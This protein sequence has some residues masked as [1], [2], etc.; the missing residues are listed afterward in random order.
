LGEQLKG[1]VRW[2]HVLRSGYR[3]ASGIMTSKRRI[4]RAEKKRRKRECVEKIHGRPIHLSRSA[5]FEGTTVGL[6][7]NFAIFLGKPLLTV[8]R[9]T[10]ISD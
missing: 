6:G 8:T 1:E 9:K 4:Y 7:Y 2:V 10:R 5:L 3:T